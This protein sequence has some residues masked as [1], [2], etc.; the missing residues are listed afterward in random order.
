MCCCKPLKPKIGIATT[1]VL[2]SQADAV[3]NALSA[4][5]TEGGGGGGG[6]GGKFIQGLKP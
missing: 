1:A 6:G 5:G 2:L 4:R 3:V